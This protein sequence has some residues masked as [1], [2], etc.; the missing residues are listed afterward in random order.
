MYGKFTVWASGDGL[1]FRDSG[2]GFRVNHE[3][4]KLL[5]GT[6]ESA[7]SQQ[8]MALEVQGLGKP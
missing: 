1:G 5:L 7:Q 8:L 2:S 4:P 6:Q 3:I